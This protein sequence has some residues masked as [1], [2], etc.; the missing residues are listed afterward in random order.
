VYINKINIKNFR[1]LRDTT[2]DVKKGLSLLI[3]KNN[4]GKTSFIVI[5]QKFFQGNDKFNLDDYPL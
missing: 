4:S 5:F 2:L 3:G 1:L